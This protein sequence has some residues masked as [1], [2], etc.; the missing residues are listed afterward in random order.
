MNNLNLIIN[1]LK[2]NFNPNLFFG[3]AYLL[4]VK[5]VAVEWLVEVVVE[6]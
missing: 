5:E 4:L 6:V 2:R 3:L 1:N